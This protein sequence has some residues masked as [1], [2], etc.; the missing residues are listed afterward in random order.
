MRH[1]L[2][3]TSQ[4]SG[5]DTKIFLEDGTEL[6]NVRSATIWLEANA[7]NQ[8]DLVINHPSVHTVAVVDE[9]TMTC[10]ICSHESKHRCNDNSQGT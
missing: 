9:V 2:Q 4:G 3:I 1:Q 5:L 8:V 10:P 6:Q 7:V